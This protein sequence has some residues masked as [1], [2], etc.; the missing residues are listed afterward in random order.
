MAHMDTIRRRHALRNKTGLNLLLI[1][2]GAAE[3]AQ[4]TQRILFAVRFRRAARRDE[5]NG[6]PLA[7]AMTWREAAELFAS[8]TWLA[9]WCWREWERI[10]RL[11]RYMA[12]PIGADPVERG[13]TVQPPAS[14][15][16]LAEELF[17][18]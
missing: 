16:Q 14:Q 15:P 5:K 13:E 12:D 11:P 2:D 9:N 4:L 7:A 3:E 18:A 6:F 1:C 17:A 10:M 8:I